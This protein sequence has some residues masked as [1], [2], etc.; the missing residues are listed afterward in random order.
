MKRVSQY[1]L[2]LPRK[3]KM[4]VEAS[5]FASDR[6]SLDET[7]VRQLADG[8]SIPSVNRA[9]ATPDIHQGYGVPIGSVLGMAEVV[10]PAAVGFD[11]NCGMRVLTTSL[12]AADTNLR[13]LAMSARRDIPLGEGKSNISMARKDLEMVLAR[14]V[15]GLLDVKHTGHKVWE[16]W[17]CDDERS[18]I[19]RIEDGGSLDGDP[20]AVSDTAFRRGANQLGSLGGGNH[21][22]EFQIV[23]EIFEPSIAAR[24][25]LF[26]D[27][28]VVM[29]HSGSR[30]LGHQ[31]GGDYM[32]LAAK[33]TGG[34]SQVPYLELDSE[35]GCRYVGAMNAAAN[36]AFANRH[37]MGLLVAR[38]IRYIYPDASIQLLYDVP[39]NI[40]KFERHAKQTLLVHRKGATRAFGPR[41]M[42][43]SSF[44]D[45]GQPV[46]IPGSMGT[47]SY[48]L[49]GV[50][51]N[52]RSL[53]SVNHG[54]GRAMSRTQ[55]GGK[56]RKGKM[57]KPP[58]VS[59]EEFERAME[60]V[61]LITES[62]RSVKEEAP[63]AY[64][65]IDLVMETVLGAQLAT[66]VA[67]LRPRAV[68][69]G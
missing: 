18:N 11:I 19:F 16:S 42:A 67:R 60:G 12:R 8:A 4:L 41:R 49:A 65:D 3:G 37:L 33:L 51:E 50:D 32:K 34:R 55:A 20:G 36:F 45:T 63:Q 24:F 14:G 53:D 47:S 6:I 31:V 48:I 56:W 35:E 15:S 17:N 38:N 2:K 22:V 10:V 58:A 9:L 7:A 5:I 1:E 69:K 27:Q 66:A 25:G 21:F 44:A 62:R 52:S 68:L 64:K 59:D 29:I 57:I 30:G 54:A 43:G 28:L 40:A 23:E 26:Q 13:Q 39:H 46:L 61:V